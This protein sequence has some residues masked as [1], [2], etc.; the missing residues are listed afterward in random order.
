[1]ARIQNRAWVTVALIFYAGFAG[2]ARVL[3]KSNR[4]KKAAA[5]FQI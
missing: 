2:C 4:K 5:D 3:R 1:M